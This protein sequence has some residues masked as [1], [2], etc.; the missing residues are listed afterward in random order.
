MEI[1]KEKFPGKEA[2]KNLLAFLKWSALALVSGIVIGLIGTAFHFCLNGALQLRQEHPWLVWLLP[3]GGVV[4]TALYQWSGINNDR[5]TNFVLIAVRANEKLSFK[6]APLIFATTFLTHLFGGSA[7]REGA[8]LQL[9]GSLAAKFGRILHLDEKD[10]RILTMC[11][12]SAAFSALFGTPVTS[13][14]FSMEVISVGVMY[15]SAIVPCVIAAVIGDRISSLFGIAP[16]ECALSGVPE[17][18]AFGVTK[19]VL[20]GVLCA[21]L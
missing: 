15:Y 2:V 6:T 16:T 20:L 11:G 8:A 21:V 14:I 17:M 12:M 3:A 18:T 5:G 4:I 1:Q 7:G 13:A 19:V 9:G 10:A